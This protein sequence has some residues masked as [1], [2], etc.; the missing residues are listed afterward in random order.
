MLGKPRF[1]NEILSQSFQIPDRT[2]SEKIETF[3]V[4]FKKSYVRHKVNYLGALPIT[5][6]KKSTSLSALQ[7]PLKDL[8]F[9]W[10]S[11]TTIGQE[12]HHQGS[13]EI[14]DTGL[15]VQYIRELHKGVQEIFN[16]FSSIAVWAA[17]KFVHRRDFIQEDFRSDRNY[18][19]HRYAFLPLISDPEG[20]DKSGLYNN[21]NSENEVE[22]A[23][24]SPHPPIFACVMRRNGGQKVLECH[25]FVCSSSE[26][27]IV[28][29]ANLYQAL[30]ETMKKQKS[31]KKKDKLEDENANGKR[32]SE[33]HVHVEAPI[34]PPR[35]KKVIR[36]VDVDTN[37]SGSGGTLERRNS[38]RRSVR[39]SRANKS[40]RGSG[41]KRPGTASTA[42]NGFITNHPF[43]RS[44][45]R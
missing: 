35:R 27:A 9:K 26:D 19:L 6:S 45:M 10:L 36:P 13:L 16:P 1:S 7:K 33:S 5:S 41:R 39:S 25:G 2:P 14:N 17:V 37:S 44:T 23:S 34:R 29:A 18:I 42:T 20:N 28:I 22:L 8:Y 38:M 43:R 11:I 32:E 40:F 4:E 12:S 3:P 31:Q 24:A 30:V 15:S 21:L